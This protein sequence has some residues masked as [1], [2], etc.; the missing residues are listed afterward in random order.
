M[1]PYESWDEREKRI[2]NLVK[3]GKLRMVLSTKRKRALRRK[4]VPIWWEHSV[5]AFIWEPHHG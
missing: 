2:L 5:G 4:G 1:Y 3:L